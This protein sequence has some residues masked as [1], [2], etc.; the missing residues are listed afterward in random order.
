MNKYMHQEVISTNTKFQGK[1]SAISPDDR[2]IEVNLM[3]DPGYA[4]YTGM[5]TEEACVMI[6][7]EN[8]ELEIASCE[9]DKSGVNKIVI[10][11]KNKNEVKNP[12]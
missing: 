4:T 12:Y 10:R 6:K 8:P 9:Q 1:E 11:L 5:S 2:R 3:S 7:K